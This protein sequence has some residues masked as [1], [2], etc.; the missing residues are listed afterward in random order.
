MAKADVTT[1]AIKNIISNPMKLKQ[2]KIVDDSKS[3]TEYIEFVSTSIFTYTAMKE[4]RQKF[5]M[6]NERT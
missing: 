3:T 2:F 5:A 1:N 6:L 4:N